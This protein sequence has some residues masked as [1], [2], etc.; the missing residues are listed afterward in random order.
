LPEAV[1]WFVVLVC[2]LAVLMKGADLFVDHA[3]VLAKA[4]GVPDFVV[5][6]TLVALGTSLPELS[7]SMVSVATG[8]GEFVAG[9]VVGSNVANLTFIM[10][11]AALAFK[12][13]NVTPKLMRLDLPIMLLAGV[14][15]SLMGLGG[16][17]SRGEGLVLLAMYGLY[18][19]STVRHQRRHEQQEREG[20]LRPSN[21]V[22]LAAGAA[23]VYLGADFTVKSV[24]RL[25]EILGLA[26]VSVLALSVVA[27]GSS[28]PELVVSLAAA[29][30]SYHDLSVGNV[31]GSNICNSFLVMGGTAVVKPLPYSPLVW[32][33]GVPF[34]LGASF[35][36]WLFAQRGAVSRTAGLFLL[37]IFVLFLGTMAGV[38]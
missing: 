27:V 17:V 14:V 23:A 35:L 5:G 26:D 37:L 21:F 1:I 16:F 22:W 31:V 11:S 4:L 29:K 2:A 25:T 12:G 7:A 13:F 19:A 38:F 8:A 34:M 32:E 20:R 36:F 30:K 15:I 18:L 24:V 28:L 6:V 9:T 33:V 10:G 3:A